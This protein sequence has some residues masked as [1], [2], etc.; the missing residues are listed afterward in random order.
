LLAPSFVPVD[1]LKPK[2]GLALVQASARRQL[3]LF[4]DELPLLRPM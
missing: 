1:G 3:R 4:D 2:S